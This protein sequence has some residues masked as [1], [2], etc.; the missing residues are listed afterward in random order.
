MGRSTAS[1]LAVLLGLPAANL[2]AQDP[3]PDL[4]AVADA[5]RGIGGDDPRVAIVTVPGREPLLLMGGST[6]AGEPVTAG[7][8]VALGDTSRQ[9]F[10]DALRAT[11][12]EDLAQVEGMKVGNEKVTIQ[13]LLAGCPQIPDHGIWPGDPFAEPRA[14]EP[15][16][17]RR[18][19][20]VAED[21]DVTFELRAGVAEL[22]LLEAHLMGD[23]LPD[24]PTALRTALAPRIPGFDPRDARDLGAAERTLIVNADGAVLAG[25]EPRA[26]RLVVPVSA[27]AQWARWRMDDPGGLLNGP[28]GGGTH[29]L[30]GWPD[31]E[32]WRLRSSSIAELQIHALPQEGAA[33]I[34][35]GMTRT[36]ETRLFLP[37][38]EALAGPPE[39][40]EGWN[41]VIGLGGRAVRPRPDFSKFGTETWTDGDI[42]IET[43]EWKLALRTANG[44]SIGAATVKHPTSRSADVALGPAPNGSS[45]RLVLVLDDEPERKLRVVWVQRTQK[46]GTLT[47]YLELTPADR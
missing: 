19:A 46:H 9:L 33:L 7:S 21:A 18:C 42:T 2:A 3:G 11:M 4:S 47:R 32:P 30:T 17:V 14:L 26:L 13:D 29:T 23:R 35:S 25:A 10:A 37:L 6:A 15:E 5:F 8:L 40:P 36:D 27:L 20:A 24:L 39:E 44:E 41:S 28:R 12:G 1:S 34:T 45:N 38:V 31:L 16:E 22:V 43:S